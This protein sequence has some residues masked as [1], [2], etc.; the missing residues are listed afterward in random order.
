MAG[1]LIHLQLVTSEF[2]GEDLQVREAMRYLEALLL[3]AHP[4]W[5]DKVTFGHA[6]DSSLPVHHIP[7]G[8]EDRQNLPHG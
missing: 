1:P 8:D 4:Q 3:E 2:L 7:S 5:V 6:V